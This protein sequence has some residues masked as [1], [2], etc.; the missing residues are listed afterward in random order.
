MKNLEALSGRTIRCILFDFGETLWTRTDRATWYALEQAGNLRTLKLLRDHIDPWT[1]PMTDLTLLGEQLRKA[2]EVHARTLIRRNP[3]Y[4]PDFTSVTIEALQQLGFPEVDE[5]LGAAVFEAQ[6][7][8]IAQSRH[9]FRDVLPT[10]K[11][12]QQRGFLLGVVTNRNYGG[13]PFQQDLQTMG[14]LDYFDPCHMA[15]SADLGIRKP[16]AA[17]FQYVLNAL[18]VPPEEAV[19]VG[20][21]LRADVGGALPLGIFAVWKPSLRVRAEARAALLARSLTGDDDRTATEP[22]LPP[23][24]L[25]VAEVCRSEFSV[26]SLGEDY[27]LAYGQQRDNK[28]EHHRHAP[29][30]PDWIIENVSELLDVFTEAG[31]Q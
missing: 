11:A 13:A 16:N 26:Q 14:L 15:I 22:V 12:L 1:M 27:L 25:A 18:D 5:A 19:M 23:D 9:I 21:S 10:L 29:I 30:K 4:E 20:D 24:P 2:I 17:I 28:K 6:R 8:S 31:K 7:V 3:G